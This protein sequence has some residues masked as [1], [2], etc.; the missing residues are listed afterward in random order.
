MGNIREVLTEKNP[1]AIKANYPSA[2]VT[3]AATG[4][5]LQKILLLNISQNYSCGEEFSD[6]PPG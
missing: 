3:E 6:N 5:V 4:C 2:E 1:I